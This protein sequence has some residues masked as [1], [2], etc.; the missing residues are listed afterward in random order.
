MISDRPKRK[1]VLRRVESSLQRKQAAAG[2][3]RRWT[4]AVY[5]LARGHPIDDFWRPLRPRYY[6]WKLWAYYLERGFLVGLVVTQDGQKVAKRLIS[7]IASF[8]VIGGTALALL[9]CRPYHKRNEN[10]LG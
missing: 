8:I 4:E 6:W 5:E 9:A 7:I 2:Q 1:A 10:P 3:S